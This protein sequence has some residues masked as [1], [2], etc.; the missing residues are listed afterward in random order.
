[1]L[2]QIY[3]LISCSARLDRMERKV[4]HGDEGDLSKEEKRKEV[5][6]SMKPRL[7]LGSYRVYRYC[8]LW[9][10][11]TAQSYTVV[12]V[13]Q[14]AF[15]DSTGQAVLISLSRVHAFSNVC[16]VDVERKSKRKPNEV[17]AE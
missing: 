12:G 15:H 8:I 13:L 16:H 7:H 11:A 9:L 4:Y 5:D 14:E 3:L 6:K 2:S 17:M 1:M 10:P